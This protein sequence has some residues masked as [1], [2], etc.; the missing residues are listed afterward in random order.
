VEDDNTTQ[1]AIIDTP[2]TFVSNA[3]RLIKF[4]PMPNRSGTTAMS[5]AL[6]DGSF[7]FSDVLTVQLAVFPVN[8][9]PVA[10]PVANPRFFTVPNTDLTLGSV[11]TLSIS[12]VDNGPSQISG[13]FLTLPGKGTLFRGDGVTPV[14]PSSLSIAAGETIFVF[15]ADPYTNGSPFANYT[16]QVTDGQLLSNVGTDII[17]VV[18]ANTPPDPTTVADSEVTTLEDTPVNISLGAIDPD[19]G[20][21]FFDRIFFFL[22]KLPSSGTLEILN[23]D[24]TWSTIVAVPAQL[25]DTLAS[26]ERL[27]LRYTPSL[28]FNTPTATPPDTIKYTLQDTRLFAWPFEETVNLF[29]TPV[30]DAPSMSATATTAFCDTEPN[31]NFVPANVVLT[32]LDDAI[33]SASLTVTVNATR[34]QSISMNNVANVVVNTIDSLHFTV[35]GTLPLLTAAFS[36]GISFLPNACPPLVG[37]PCTGTMT[38]VAQDFGSYGEGAGNSL[39]Q[40]TEFSKNIHIDRYNSNQGPPPTTEAAVGGLVGVT[41]LV[42]LSMFG[43]Y[44]LMKRRKLIPEEAD[45]WENDELFDATL[46]NPLYSG[47]TVT[48]NAVFDE[49]EE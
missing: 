26:G 6:L 46:D 29:V 3:N 20:S 32:L 48:M 41:T 33:S 49:A 28:N 38:F 31:N 7:M 10:N 24:D 4:V 14:T 13:S 9:A 40:M 15:R 34:A 36:S 18:V 27:T 44:R 8:D 42:S 17:N 23:R 22:T 2:F 30:N 5:Y 12:D 25:L 35:T 45:P 16:W 47:A 11:L 39:P 21:P 37:F 19:A 1:G 43:A